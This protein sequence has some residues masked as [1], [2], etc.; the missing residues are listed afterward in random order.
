MKL[1]DHKKLIQT[2]EY[3]Y[4]EIIEEFKEAEQS[5]I[6]DSQFRSIFRKKDYDGNI[7]LLRECKKKTLRIDL[8]DI[9]IN[10]GDNDTK[11]VLRQLERTLAA[12]NALCDSYIQLQVFLKKKAMKEEAKFSA[13]KDIFNQVKEDKDAVNSQL[14]QLDIL[15]TDYTEQF[16]DDMGAML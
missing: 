12:F 1:S 9:K 6:N 5:I 16:E 10:T 3:F 4:I 2:I 8:R 14:H 7:A 13:Y 15:Y 11:E